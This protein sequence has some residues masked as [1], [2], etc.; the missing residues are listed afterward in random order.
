MLREGVGMCTIVYIAMG[1][2][3]TVLHTQYIMYSAIG[4][5]QSTNALCS[6]LQKAALR[7]SYALYYWY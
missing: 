3:T 7:C 4:S 1:N 2:C 5:C 6:V